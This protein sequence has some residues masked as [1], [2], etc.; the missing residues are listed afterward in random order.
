MV[1]ELY[2]SPETLLIPALSGDTRWMMAAER[3][4]AG[5]MWAPDTGRKMVARVAVASPATR[6]QYS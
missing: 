6:P 4:R 3:E 1:V 5:L 2:S